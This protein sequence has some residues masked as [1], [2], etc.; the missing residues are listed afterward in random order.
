MNAGLSEQQ[1]PQASSSHEQQRLLI[2]DDNDDWRRILGIY[3]GRQGYE[4]L[5]A[6]SG[7]EGLE[8]ARSREP[9]LVVLDLV[10]PDT[11]GFT[12]CQEL[13]DAPETCGIPV[14]IVSGMEHNDIVRRAR[15][16]GCLFFVQKPYDPNAL[17]VLVRQALNENMGWEAC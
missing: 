14:I 13:A 17:L 9:H 15:L 2:I 4:V 5:T 8:I 16:A 12:V 1:Q 11:D 6:P 7:A 3:L 10:L